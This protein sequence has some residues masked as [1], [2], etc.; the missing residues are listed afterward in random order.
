MKKL[1]LLSLLAMLTL[2]VSAQTNT[3]SMVIEMQNG[4]KLTIGPN[5]VKNVSFKNGE[6]TVSGETIETLVNNAVN[7]A[8]AYTNQVKAEVSSQIV[9]NQSAIISLAQEVQNNKNSQDK[10][11][12]TIQSDVAQNA[13]VIG[14]HDTKIQ[15]LQNQLPE[16]DKT[17]KAY[18][19]NK[20]KE[21]GDA[22]QLAAQQYADN[23]IVSQS[24]Q[25]KEAWE[26]AINFAIATLVQSYQLNTLEEKIQSAQ[27]N[28]VTTATSK[29]DELYE[30]VMSAIAAQAAADRI[31]WEKAINTSANKLVQDY[32][33]NMLLDIISS[34]INAAIA[35][36][37]EDYNL[38]MP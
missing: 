15:N 18:A 30:R 22:A 27:S 29:D 7:E 1:F 21:K 33:L 37:I 17:L 38:Q 11:N 19:D 34:Q 36:L 10:I 2:T 4:T 25:D 23:Q 28:A 5:E 3:Y 12:N 13:V 14:E 20:A 8:K 32:Q 16:L 26:A 31:S 24:Q 9:T 35:K 6:L